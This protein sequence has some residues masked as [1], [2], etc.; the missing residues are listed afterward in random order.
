QLY[1]L[2]RRQELKKVKNIPVDISPVLAL[3]RAWGPNES[4]SLND[5]ISKLA[6][7]L[8]I[9]GFL[10]PDDIRC[11]DV[12]K[13][14]VNTEGILLVHLV[15]PKEKVDG[16]S[17]VVDVHISPAADPLICPVQAYSEYLSRLPP[18][19]LSLRHHKHTRMSPRPDTV[20]LLR[21]LD[22]P[23]MSITPAT[24]S[25]KMKSI[26]RHM[27][28]APG[29]IT[30]RCRAISSTLAA[31]HGISADDIKIHGRWSPLSGM[32]EKFYRLTRGSAI[33]FSSVVLAGSGST[34]SVP[35]R[36]DGE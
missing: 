34:A 27:E 7:L 14:K 24:I 30:P 18:N 19:L 1:T 20:P 23:S 25:E 16:K 4:L 2:A 36:L 6:W 3:F 9:C 10:R 8:G 21:F 35:G 12:A 31:L 33:N 13:S 5:L 22:N 29:T 11:I 26:T 15:A 32:F 17:T 28:L